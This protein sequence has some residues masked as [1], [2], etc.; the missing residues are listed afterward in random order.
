MDFLKSCFRKDPHDRPTA[1][2][3]MQSKWMEPFFKKDS[4]LLLSPPSSPENTLRRSRSEEIETFMKHQ[5]IDYQITT[6]DNQCSGCYMNIT[7]LWA[8]SCQDCHL[9]FH[10]QCIRKASSCVSLT[11]QERRLTPLAPLNNQVN[12]KKKNYL[13]VIHTPSSTNHRHY[14]HYKTERYPLTKT[15]AGRPLASSI[16]T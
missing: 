10:P 3:L 6:R 1:L 9:N 14:L 4:S 11:S 2:E 15:S 16:M 5:L 13:P 8:K 12:S 7:N